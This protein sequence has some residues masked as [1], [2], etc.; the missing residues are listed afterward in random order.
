MRICKWTF[1]T[2]FLPISVKGGREGVGGIEV[3]QFHSCFSDFVFKIRSIRLGFSFRKKTK[4]CC[5]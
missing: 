4:S 2:E 5:I 1:N 3:V